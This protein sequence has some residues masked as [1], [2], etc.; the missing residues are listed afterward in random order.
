MELLSDTCR[1]TYS[2][3]MVNNGGSGLFI[4]GEGLLL[5]VTYEEQ[6]ENIIAIQ[7]IKDYFC[8]SLNPLPRL[9]S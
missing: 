4:N 7:K 2:H 9:P 8:Y 3:N 1:M 5:N 6:L